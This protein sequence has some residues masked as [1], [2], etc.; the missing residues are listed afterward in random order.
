[1]CSFQGGRG[2]GEKA[3]GKNLIHLK[4]V[5]FRSRAANPRPVLAIFLSSVGW[6]Q[7]GMSV[8]GQ[9]GRK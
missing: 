1:M 9:G 6:I 8:S 4:P 7:L 5:L 2:V 3:K